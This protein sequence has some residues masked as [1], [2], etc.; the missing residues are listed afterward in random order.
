[1]DTALESNFTA[2][3]HLG[4]YRIQVYSDILTSTNID[5]DKECKQ[6]GKTYTI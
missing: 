3:C 5:K 4:Y 6:K 2:G 1:M